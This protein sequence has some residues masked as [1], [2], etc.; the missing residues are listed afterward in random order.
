MTAVGEG[1]EGARCGMAGGNL[2]LDTRLG[3]DK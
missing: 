1:G 3:K 2:A